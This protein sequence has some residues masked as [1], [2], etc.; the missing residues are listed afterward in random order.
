MEGTDVCFAPVLSL[1]EAPNHPHN[2]ARGTFVDY[3][4]VVQ[5]APSPRFS[6][7]PPEIQGPPAHPGQ[8]TDEAL[9]D[10]GLDAGRIAELRASGAIA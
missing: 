10:W 3:A 1:L 5:P 6:A 8:H 4:G 7:T 9:A 2:Q